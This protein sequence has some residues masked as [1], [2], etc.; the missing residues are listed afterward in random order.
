MSSTAEAETK[1]KRKAKESQ[2]PKEASTVAKKPKREP[3][4]T[5]DATAT[6][7]TSNGIHRVEPAQEGKAKKAQAKP[8]QPAEDK[9][10]YESAAIP[11][12]KEKPVHDD[13]NE[14]R[15]KKKKHKKFV[16]VRFL[17]HDFVVC[18]CVR[19]SFS[20]YLFLCVCLMRTSE[21]NGT[22]AGGGAGVC[23]GKEGRREV[24]R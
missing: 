16:E 20:L 12:P 5:G 11:K 14:E 15:Q 7:Q 9:K 21:A 23:S 6:A 19:L 13:A 24:A 8:K 1:G 18:M 10:G 2:Q 4:E 17:L 3:K 22:G